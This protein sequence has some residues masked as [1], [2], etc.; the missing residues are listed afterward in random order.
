MDRLQ[1]MQVFV[2]VAESGSFVGAA[3]KLTMSPPTITRTVAALESRLGVQLFQRT[4]RSVRLTETGAR[5]V[6][7]ARHLLLEFDTAEKELVGESADVAGVLTISASVTFGRYVLAPIVAEFLNAH[8]QVNVSMMLVERLVDLVDEGV[9]L[10][11]RIAELRDSTLIARRVGAVRRMLVA[12]PDYLKAFGIPKT[13]P[14]LAQHR[15]IA[16]TGLIQNRE[17]RYFDKGREQSFSVD[18]RME[19][20]DAATAISA[21]EAGQGITGVYSYMVSDA[22]RE[23]RLVPILEGYAFGPVPVQLVYPQGRFMAPKLRRFLDFSAPRLTAILD[24]Q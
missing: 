17:L 4:T 23:G 16:F 6:G 13:I 8:P 15:M 18:M 22:L 21:A 10:A 12:S 5:F 11:V 19:V 2:A 24:N 7:T 1:E 3:R 20:N 14:A 9:D